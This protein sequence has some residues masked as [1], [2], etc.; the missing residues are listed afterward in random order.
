MINKRAKTINHLNSD[1]FNLQYVVRHF[2]QNNREDYE[3]VTKIYQAFECFVLDNTTCG[4]NGDDDRGKRDND[5]LFIYS[6]FLRFDADC[7]VHQSAIY[8]CM[9]FFE[10]ERERVAIREGNIEFLLESFFSEKHE[11]LIQFNSPE[12]VK[13]SFIEKLFPV[14]KKHLDTVEELR[15]KYNYFTYFSVYALSI[16][17]SFEKIYN[18]YIAQGTQ[19]KETFPSSKKTAF[20][21]ESPDQTNIYNCWIFRHPSNEDLDLVR[22][23]FF[24]HHC[25]NLNLIATSGS[26]S[27]INTTDKQ[28]AEAVILKVNIENGHDDIDA[29]LDMFKA[30]VSHE[31]RI[32]QE[33]SPDETFT[34]FDSDFHQSQKRLSTKNEIRQSDSI[35]TNIL[36]LWCW[37]DYNLNNN[38][39][40]NLE[41][42]CGDVQGK[43]DRKQEPFRKNAGN[44]LN[45]EDSE[46]QADV[47]TIKSNY[48]KVK[49]LIDRGCNAPFFTIIKK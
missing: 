17:C 40:K 37:D 18:E 39:E 36:G 14:L 35:L 26:I 31:M 42:V 19:L 1:F 49:K 34:F 9:L 30:S 24:N 45:M 20:S 32:L 23:Y 46:F 22:A 3:Q 11:C 10:H 13:R 12:K 8:L 28:Q 41:G 6:E 29:L 25:Y 2:Y 21:K 15:N 43:R 5:L 44:I 38:S 4:S 47:F 27:F 33:N 48:N 16:K 7:F